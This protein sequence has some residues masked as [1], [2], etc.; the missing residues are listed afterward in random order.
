VGHRQQEVAQV[1]RRAL[2]IAL[3][4]ALAAPA[5]FAQSDPSK[6]EQAHVLMGQG[7]A[8]AAMLMMRE[9]VAEHPGDGAARMDLARYLAW[10]GDYAQAERVLLADPAAADS[11]E[12]R[13]LHGYILA[14]A[15]RMH[16]AR[17]MLEPLAVDDSTAFLANYSEAL[18]LALGTRP[19]MA[20]AYVASA[21]HLQPENRDVDDLQ[22]RV[23]VRHAS[24]LR[25][26]LSHNWSSDELS[27][28][29]PTLSGEYA[30][31]EA[32]RLTGEL[33]GWR[34][35]SDGA[36][37][38]YEAIGGGD[39]DEHRLLLGLRYAPT[40]YTE[41]GF[42]LGHSS[43][44]GDGTT[45][46]RAYGSALFSDSFSGSLQVERDRVSAS[47]R[48][49]SLGLTRQGAELHLRFT[50]DLNW[51]GD[52]WARTDDYSDDNTRTDLVLALRRAAIRKPKLILDLGGVL[53]HL[54]YDA[55]SLN[56]YYAPD[57]YRRYGLTAH[58][59][60]GLGKERGLSLH[61]VLGRQRDELF[62]SWH[63]AN[64]LDATL[65][66][67]ALSKWETR[68]TVAYSQRAQNFGAYE[69]YSVSAVITRRF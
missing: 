11:P 44:E 47:P 18:A 62:D 5:A 20:E 13:A 34:Y 10:N 63:S 21:R 8:E 61:A 9:H 57:N 52:L 69:G 38:P 46:W 15:G 59:Y 23:W 27:S 67:G 28:L 35:G 50:P 25:L 29:Q 4:L 19:E 55:Y 7:N 49:L 17:L 66:L 60:V 39:V 41:I 54:H 68:L 36:G 37:N 53:E 64:D 56:G 42:A 40:E 26:A 12:G 2:P 51:T 45:L 30:V 43:L 32:L 58:A 65:V 1:K 16:D 22:K 33:G 24:F 6:A 14:S 3:V 48:S 31:N